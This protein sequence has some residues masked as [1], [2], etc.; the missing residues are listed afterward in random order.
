[1]TDELHFIPLTEA[2]LFHG[3]EIRRA[4]NAPEI[5]DLIALEAAL[6]APKVAF[7]GNRLMDLYEMAATYVESICT[8]HPFLDGDKRTGA[9]CALAFLYFNGYQLN[10]RHPEELADQVLAL[11]THRINKSTLA[12]YFRDG[13]IPIG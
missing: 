10:E 12:D 1:M 6:A 7:G 11:V 8:H 13:S 2:L 4:G 9:L 3:E 5:R